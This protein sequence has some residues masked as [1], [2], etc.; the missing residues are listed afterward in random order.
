MGEH[1]SCLNR[2]VLTQLQPISA[3]REIGLVLTDGQIFLK[4]DIKE[5]LFLN[6][7]YISL[8]NVVNEFKILKHQ[9]S[10]I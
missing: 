5:D 7:K 1:R 6:V 4:R 8:F 9:A 3:I 2:E 10:Q